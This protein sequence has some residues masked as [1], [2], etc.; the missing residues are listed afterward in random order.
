VAFLFD[1]ISPKTLE[2]LEIV[3]IDLLGIN[4]PCRLITNQDLEVSNLKVVVSQALIELWTQEHQAGLR[5]SMSVMLGHVG[6]WMG[7]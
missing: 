3:Q 6:S 5:M 4:G 2:R 7:R 1:P